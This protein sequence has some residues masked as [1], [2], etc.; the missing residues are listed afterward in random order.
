MR[1]KLIAL[2]I[3]LL[4]LSLLTLGI[5]DSQFAVIRQFYEQ[6]SVIP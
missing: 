6:M 2:I 1:N 4:G 5:M 3:L